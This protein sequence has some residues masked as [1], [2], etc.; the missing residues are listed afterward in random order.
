MNNDVGVVVITTQ[1][2]PN[3]L[4]QSCLVG[5]GLDTVGKGIGHSPGSLDGVNMCMRM[6]KPSQ[7]SE[8]EEKLTVMVGSSELS[9]P[10]HSPSLL[11]LPSTFTVPFFPVT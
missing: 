1:Y 2:G 8:H 10:H 4:L 11:L 3:C 7:A 5:R 9:P 6:V